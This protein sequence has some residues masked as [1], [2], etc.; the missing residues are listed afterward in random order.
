MRPAP[1]WT[2]HV[3]VMVQW[4]FGVSKSS[5]AD[6]GTSGAVRAET[7]FEADLFT[8]DEA[9]A[10]LGPLIAKVWDYCEGSTIRGRTVTLKARYADFR[11]V[12][13]SRTDD[14]NGSRA[15]RD[16]VR[17]GAFRI[18]VQW[19]RSR[20]ITHPISEMKSRR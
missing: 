7:T 14:E 19:W 16:G 12:T 18:A 17:G 1:L 10:A 4:S 11:Q 9:R 2:A 8:L 15:N 20:G 6:D 13:R 5:A 3:P